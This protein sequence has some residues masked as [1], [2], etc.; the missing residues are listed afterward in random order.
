M[1]TVID[2]IETSFLK[3]NI[4]DFHIGDTLTLNVKIIEGD[5]ERTQAFEGTLICMKGKS[6]GKTIT[7]RKF[8]FGEG[9]E[10]TFFLHSP[11]IESIKVVKRG[12]VRRAKLYYLRSKIGKS[13][14]VE[15]RLEE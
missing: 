12:K 4:P 10:R 14:K 7:L 8:S 9:V 1:S 5:K 13:S 6:S 15:E 3:D 2:K 11:L